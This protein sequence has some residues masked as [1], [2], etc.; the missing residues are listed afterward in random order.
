MDKTT[1]KNDEA[2]QAFMTRISTARSLL[3][4]LEAH[5]DDH[6]GISPE[7]V[8]WANAGDAGRLVEKL[9][10]IAEAFQAVKK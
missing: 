6:M 8:T 10:D 4:A 3:S 2:L 1:L 9:E 7:D 5:L